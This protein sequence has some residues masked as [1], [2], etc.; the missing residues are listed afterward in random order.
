[1]LLTVAMGALS[2]VGVMGGAIFGFGGGRRTGERKTRGHQRVNW[3]SH[4]AG[5]LARSAHRNTRMPGADIPRD[6][7]A[8]DDPD[9]R[10]AEMLARLSRNAA[11]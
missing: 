2:L 8:A 6:P 1:M 3:G 11:A 4:D 7:R 10:I 5:D 9:R